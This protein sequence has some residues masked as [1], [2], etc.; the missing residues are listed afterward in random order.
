MQKIVTNKC[1]GGFDLSRE[2]V[3]R[4][5]EIKGL[6]LYPDEDKEFASILGPTYWLVP[7]EDR[8]EP[9]D[10]WYQWTMEKR[11]ESNEAHD[12]AQLTPRD[13]PRDESALVQVIEELGDAASGKF[14]KLRVVEIPDD[15]EWQIEEYDGLEWVAEKHRTW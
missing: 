9:Q 8:P 6:T 11:R 4:Y 15:V 3:L 2:A 7:T 1:Y 14:A 12:K 5:A 10:N 13:I